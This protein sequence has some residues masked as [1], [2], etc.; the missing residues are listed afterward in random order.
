MKG[1]RSVFTK[2]HGL[3]ILNGERF[4]RAARYQPSRKFKKRRPEAHSTFHRHNSKYVAAFESHQQWRSLENLLA[5]AWSA[6]VSAKNEICTK[7]IDNNSRSY[8]KALECSIAV[9]S[10]QQYRWGDRWVRSIYWGL[11]T[12]RIWKPKRQN[13]SWRVAWLRDVN[14]THRC[15]EIGY[16]TWRC[17]T[18]QDWVSSAGLKSTVGHVHNPAR[19]PERY[20]KLKR[21][22][23]N[24]WENF[25]DTQFR[26][27]QHSRDPEYRFVELYCTFTK[28]FI[29]C[30]SNTSSGRAALPQCSAIPWP[31]E[32]SVHEEAKQRSIKSSRCNC[33]SYKIPGPSPRVFRMIFY[34][35]RS[36]R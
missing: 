7:F 12:I 9:S 5:V 17:Y 22:M 29:E 19:C 2:C 15:I 32:A 11:L 26:L 14:S 21:E 4:A 33:R 6:S 20:A 35:W 13:H 8:A 36:H 28:S 18:S 10:N 1:L 34:Y 3:K 25:V 24:F 16:C 23:S 30:S 27:G 31:A